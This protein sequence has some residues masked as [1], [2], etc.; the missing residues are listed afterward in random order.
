M[1]SIA[2]DSLDPF[3]IEICRRVRLR[4][5]G[6]RF[7]ASVRPTKAARIECKELK[8]NTGDVWTPVEVERGTALTLGA[9]GFEY[10]KLSELLFGDNWQRPIALEV[11][12]EDGRSPLAIARALI[13]GQGKTEGLH[14]R[15][16]SVP[17]R[18]RALFASRE[19]RSRLGALA[20]T[21]VEATKSL[22]LRILKPALCALLQGGAPDLRL[23]DDRGDSLLDQVDHAIDAEFFARLFDDIEEDPQAQRARFDRWLRDLGKEALERGIDRL[24]IPVAV[25]ERA[26]AAAESRFSG[27]ARKYLPAAY[28]NDQRD[29]EIA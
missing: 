16:V 4:R 6:A 25:R 18:A 11:R 26:I 20:Q 17:E 2:L 1:R 22:R 24:P 23:D 13:R 12:A 10:G 21:R 19:G 9:S 3:F 8:G 29:K 27:A 15:V 14:E 5:E 28:Q 7:A